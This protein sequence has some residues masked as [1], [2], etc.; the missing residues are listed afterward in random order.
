[1]FDVY[2]FQILHLLTELF[3][4]LSSYYFYRYRST[5]ILNYLTK[6][7]HVYPLV[8]S[9]HFRHK[10]YCLV[11]DPCIVIWGHHVL[12][13]FVMFSFVVLYVM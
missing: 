6:L 13:S 4:S 8:S 2:V 11:E 12:F 10:V 1:M 9:V 3:N 5:K 7:A